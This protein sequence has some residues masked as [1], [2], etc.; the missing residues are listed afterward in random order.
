MNEIPIIPPPT[1]PTPAP[2]R[3]VRWGMI[4]FDLIVGLILVLVVGIFVV[5]PRPSVQ[6]YIAE[7][8]IKWVAKKTET[9]I[10]VESVHVDIFNQIWLKN[11]YIED[12]DCDTL[13]YARQLKLD[14][15]RLALFDKVIEIEGLSLD[16]AYINIRRPKGEFFNFEY[17]L[18]Q[19]KN[20]IAAAAKPEVSVPT[21][22][23]DTS[24]TT[25]DWRFSLDYVQLNNSHIRFKDQENTQVVARNKK[26][27]V[28][29]ENF[30]LKNKQLSF[31]NILLD[32]GKFDM[33]L[34][35]SNEK[36]DP[37][38]D[39]NEPIALTPADWD[40]KAQ[41][42]QIK[43]TDIRIKTSPT[44]VAKKGLI[45]FSNLGI[46]QINLQ[47]SQVHLHDNT[48]EGKSTELSLQEQSGFVLQRLTGDVLVSNKRISVQDIYLQTPH[49]RL[50]NSLTFKMKSLRN[51]SDF[52]HRVKLEVGLQKGS[53]LVLND[54]AYFVP[55]FLKSPILA[56]NKNKTIH[57]SGKSSNAID[58][59][60]VKDLEVRVGGT[61]LAGNLSLIGLPDVPSTNIDAQIKYLR[62]SAQEIRAI[63][64]PQ[65][66]LPTFVPKLGQISFKGDFTGFPKNFV[67][68]GQLA[69]A[70]GTV[71]S[72]IQMNMMG[73]IPHYSGDIKV[74]NL[75]LGTLTQQAD[76]GTATF[77][78]IVKGE[79][80]KIDQ[81]HTS[82]DA[83]VQQ[84]VYK[85]YAYS[86][87]TIDGEINRKLFSGRYAINDPNVQLAFSGDL[88]LN[89]STLPKYDFTADVIRLDIDKLGLLP[90]GKIPKALVIAGKTDLK[91]TG[92]N[93]DNLQGTAKLKDVRVVQQNRTFTMQSLQLESRITPEKHILNLE[94]DI[95]DANF[96]GDFKFRQLPNAFQN[97]LN[98]YFPYHISP[99]PATEAQRVNFD[100][101]IK[102]AEPITSLFVQDLQKLEKGTVKG[103]FN[104]Y[105][106]EAKLD[107][108]LPSVV[109]K[110][111]EIRNLVI[112]AQSNAN[113][114]LF[115]T[116][117]SDVLLAAKGNGKPTPLPQIQLLGNVAN[118][119]LRFD[120]YYAAD[121][122]S[123]RARLKGNLFA[124]NRDW[125]NMQFDTTL[126]VIS[127]MEWNAQTGRFNYNLRTKEFQVDDIVLTQ[128]DQKIFLSSYPLADANKNE[129]K[130]LIE[131]LRLESFYGIPVFKNIGIGGTVEKGEVNIKDLFK[132][133]IATAKLRVNQFTYKTKPLGN[134]AV[135]LSK[136]GGNNTI[137][138]QFAVSESSILG[139]KFNIQS[140][141]NNIVGNGS[142]ELPSA[143]H[144]KP[145]IDLNAYIY[146][147]KLKFL[148][149]FIGT[150]ATV[151]G[152]DI[153]GKLSVKGEINQP[154]LTGQFLVSDGLATVNYLQT[155]YSFNTKY[156]EGS[157]KPYPIEFRDRKIYFNNIDIYDVAQNKA[158][159]NGT[160]SLNDFKNMSI[161]MRINTDNFQF[162]NTDIDDNTSF[163][164]TAYGSGRVS[165]TGPLNQIYVKVNAR[166]NK[167][168]VINMPLSGDAEFAEKKIY[169]FIDRNDTIKKV[170]T[171]NYSGLTL[172]FDL[173]ITPDAEILL[174]FD[175]KAGDLMRARGKGNLQMD[176]STVGDF[177]FD[178][179]GKYELEQGSY[180]FT[181]QNVVNK[182]FKVQ[183]GGSIT[184]NGSPYDA[185]L[186]LKAIY[187]VQNAK[188]LNIFTTD[189]K[190]GMTESVRQELNRP[191]KTDVH[192]VMT[193]SLSNPN[194]DFNI[195]PRDEGN[196][197]ADELF[198]TK[199]NEI[200]RTNPNEL[201][202][203]VFG[204]LVMNNF[205]S[206]EELNID[207]N[208]SLSATVSEFLSNY[209]STYLNQAV[210]GLIPNSEL[211]VRLNSELGNEQ[212]GQKVAL[213]EVG[214]DF[215]TSIND[216][217]TFEIGGSVSANDQTGVS[218]SNNNSV[219]FANDITISYR[220]DDE[221][222]MKLKVYNKIDN[223][224]IFGTYYKQ[225]AGFSWSRDFDSLEE[226]RKKNKPQK[227]RPPTPAK[228]TTPPVVPK[229]EE[230][231]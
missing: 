17:L 92:S 75:Q 83:Q 69:S 42:L 81:L 140:P 107:V 199:M 24:K 52:L 111:N 46:Q 104:T 100:I 93:I 97:Y 5:L 132:Q 152:G 145:Y 87:I 142:I 113:Q 131:N 53:Y 117:V 21:T 10:K 62:T 33:Q 139:D 78:A 176:I 134:V 186:D 164:G 65:Q 89:D 163:Y 226:L 183:Q 41:K 110:G 185:I 146:H 170:E 56:H 192:L 90:A 191:T 148:E 193:G 19:F 130:L 57:I 68:K 25:L 9:T 195:V 23:N 14:I 198:E 73:K 208:A 187:T 214:L 30:D 227:P 61:A 175:L 136:V 50:S 203:Q 2:Q 133:Q 47:F 168:T 177:K 28:E 205:M 159:V 122:A 1:P 123:T 204:L 151:H 74:N 200:V 216:R 206:A 109:Y 108:D 13:L 138:T 95:A 213:N 141:S 202:R 64:P 115:K 210:S 15:D 222:R 220:L 18:N 36:K 158:L 99:K 58:K 63:L 121:T 169:T 182:F 101:K 166:S 149:A 103:F 8:A 67:V 76:L 3:R 22:S 157:G 85:N 96:E 144:A 43:D 118:D 11:I 147:T 105:T 231:S 165:M 86:N 77:S 72:D 37:P 128:K 48:I 221:G 16:S 54:I 70:I 116:N 40:I 94:S 174:I 143:T 127:K 49:T 179:Y 125:L 79:G 80:F 181:L 39:I 155:T 189:E 106:K 217:L 60:K 154:I 88:N 173:D 211:N 45:N 167:G 184:F 171:V 223:D 114:I 162:L 156:F 98:T 218:S 55:N 150:L 126:L 196:T 224:V 178:M 119:S 12:W 120:L 219:Q 137:Q 91:L 212:N 82:I 20:P 180:L 112:D 26:L 84:I 201:N 172:D 230:P 32:K 31:S 161:D 228:P 29:I 160:L 135:D 51:F 7:Q 129:T 229:H 44:A 215:K 6:K 124:P 209:L 4:L 153:K 34:Y 194:I 66:N 225:G 59:L 197:Q 35:S 188:R 207:V 190:D 102:N 71:V 27:L 38:K